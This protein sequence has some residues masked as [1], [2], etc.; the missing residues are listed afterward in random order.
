MNGRSFQKD[1]TYPLDRG[2][3]WSI[4]FRG[5]NL[6]GASLSGPDL[7]QALFDE[8]TIFS[9]GFGP[10]A[11]LYDVGGGGAGVTCRTFSLV[12]WIFVG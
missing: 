10:G 12:R 7:S 1:S 5:L 6:D 3:K 8:T 11:I 4:D 2:N 9:D